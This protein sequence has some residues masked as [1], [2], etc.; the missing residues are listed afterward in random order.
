MENLIISIEFDKQMFPKRH[1]CDGENISPTIRIDRIHS[2][3]LAITI[4]DWIGAF[5]NA[6][7]G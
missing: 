3:Y 6:V 2:E 5:R 7:T 1:T 4:E